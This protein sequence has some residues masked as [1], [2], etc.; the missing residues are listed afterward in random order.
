LDLI[1]RFRA[2]MINHWPQG[3]A[4]NRESGSLFFETNEGIGVELSRVESRAKDLLEETDP[5]KTFE[6]LEDWEA[7]LGIP[8]EC[9]SLEGTIAERIAVVLRKLTARGGNTFSKEFLIALAATLGYTITIEEPGVDLFRCGISRCGDRLYGVLWLF[10]IQVITDT[11]V[12]DVFRA[13][14]NR[15][16]DRLRTFENTELEC[17]ID[18][19]V[20]AHISVQYIYGS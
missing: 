2:F 7:M 8:D 3:R 17:V 10:W 5:R 9:S 14:T 19:A 12:L 13:G 15:A 18:N 20:P 6:L 16:G 4:W 1:S 11:F